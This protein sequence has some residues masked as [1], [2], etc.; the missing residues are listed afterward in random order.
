MSSWFVHGESGSDA[1]AGTQTAPFKTLNALQAVYVAGDYAFLAGKIRSHNT[2]SAPQLTLTD[3]ASPWIGQWSGQTQAQVRGDI[4]IAAGDWTVHS[5]NVY[6]AKVPA[7]LTISGLVYGWDRTNSNDQHYGHCRRYADAAA[8]VAA[9]SGGKG[10]FAY[11]GTTIY[12]YF[13]GE[14]PRSSG[15]ETGYICAEA[16]TA[17]FEFVRCTSPT[18]RDI[19]G[20]LYPVY[21][22]QFGWFAR[23]QGSPNWRVYNCRADDMGAHGIGCLGANGDSSGGQAAGV[24]LVGF[25]PV[26]TPGIFHQQNS[27]GALTGCRIGGTITPTRWRGMDDAVLDGQGQ[28]VGAMAA[29]TMVAVY[30]HADTGTPIQDVLIDG[31]TVNLLEDGARPWQLHNCPA[32]AQA[33]WWG[34]TAVWDTC[35]LRVDRSVCN[36]NAYCSWGNINACS[37]FHRRTTFRN[38]T[39]LGGVGQAAVMQMGIPV[40]EACFLFDSC[41]FDFTLDDGGAGANQVRAFKIDS[42]TGVCELRFL[43]CTMNNRETVTPANFH[44]WFDY[45]AANVLLYRGIGNLMVHR[46]TGT[47]TAFAFGD[48]GTSVANHNA[49]NDNTYMG[50]DEAN[51]RWSSNASIDTKAEWF[52]SIDTAGTSAVNVI[53]VNPF[54]NPASDFRLTAAAS[55]LKRTTSAV[56]PSAGGINGNPYAGNFGAYQDATGHKTAPSFVRDAIRAGKTYLRVGR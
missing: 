56:V 7:G 34:Q 6:K 10:K 5:G 24:T 41:V 46:A 15:Q 48:A 26:A 22:G 9:A 50:V 30:G 4:V 13:G 20:A 2:S 37:I 25:S 54:V 29:N 27:D 40:G 49:F 19:N 32:T 12:A 23:F 8:V 35:P 28:A 51:A 31:L 14:D 38:T 53:T 21:S 33:N 47:D 52:A 18:L 11:A 42:A 36:I 55:L 16:A 45:S 39:P 17:C 3:V 43:N 44:A 1:N